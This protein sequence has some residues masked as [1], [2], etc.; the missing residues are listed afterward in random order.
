MRILLITLFYEPLNNIAVTRLKAFQKY[1]TEFGHEVDVLTRHYSKKDMHT[2]NL[3]KGMLAGD[4]FVGDY[5]KNGNIIYTKYK[6]LNS[7]LKFS[8]KLPKGIKGLYNLSQ[9]DVFHYSFVEYGIKAYEDEFKNNKHD[10]IIASSP[11]PAALLLAKEINKKFGVKW[12]SDFRDSYIMGD[13]SPLFRMIKNKVLNKVIKS[14]SGYLFLSDGMR[15]INMKVFNSLNKK[16]PQA[17]IYNG[18]SIF[19]EED[20]DPVTVDKINDFKKRYKYVVAYTGSLYKQ[21]NLDFFLKNIDKNITED[22]IFILAGVQEEF[23]NEIVKNFNNKVN[24]HFFDKTS[25]STSVYLQ[26][27]ADFLLLNIWKNKYSGFSG[28]VFEYLNADTRIIVDKETPT[29]LVVFTKDYKN[30]Y[31]CNENKERYNSILKSPPDIMPITDL[32][33]IELSRKF[34][35]SKLNE[36]ILNI[37]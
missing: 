22:F 8:N 16:K 2:S 18:T 7:K 4:D 14:A 35:V 28:K 29:D 26:K 27:S 17:K 21:A 31:F 6:T 34:Q 36:F 30:I 23:K 12:I 37:I 15:D 9:L 32:Q 10:V 19:V 13:E 3:E 5:Y 24:I 25:L 20:L 11:V 33:N 1:L